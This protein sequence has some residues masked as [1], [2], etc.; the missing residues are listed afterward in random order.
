MIVAVSR[1]LSLA[2][3]DISFS[4]SVSVIPMVLAIG[5]AAAATATASS[6]MASLV[7]AILRVFDFFLTIVST[8]HSRPLNVVL[9]VAA[10]ASV[11]C[12][13]FQPLRRTILHPS[14]TAVPA[15]ANTFHAFNFILHQAILNR[16]LHSLA[17]SPISDR[18]QV[19]IPRTSPFRHIEPQSACQCILFGLLHP[20]DLFLPFPSSSLL[21][22]LMGLVVAALVTVRLGV[23]AEVAPF[24]P[25]ADRSHQRVTE[26]VFT[27]GRGL[28]IGPLELAAAAAG[29]LFAN[30]GEEVHCERAV[31]Q[32]AISS[33]EGG[34]QQTD[35]V[36]LGKCGVT[37]SGN[38]LNRIFSVIQ[39]KIFCIIV[40]FGI[41][42]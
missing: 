10:W 6:P 9:P 34:L 39:G 40:I 29:A 15:K 17:L 32:A 38:Y 1:V 7:P 24:L 42:V 11:W 31:G 28:D 12:R 3:V 37:E 33:G 23:P 22:R 8:W 21:S 19:R 25:A 27:M 35:E 5:A 18:H 14:T 4:R 20:F 36:A 16:P 30:C 26:V 2:P 41:F 13:P